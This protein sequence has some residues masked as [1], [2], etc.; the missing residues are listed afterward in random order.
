MPAL[1]YFSS[2]KYIH[3]PKIYTCVCNLT[4][5]DSIRK[6]TSTSIW[7]CK[8]IKLTHYLQK[9]QKTTWK[10][11]SLPLSLSLIF[12]IKNANSQNIPIYS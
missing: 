3:L 12:T 4:M 1:K 7:I 8:F 9:R 6:K 10:P 11:L 2:P 5:K